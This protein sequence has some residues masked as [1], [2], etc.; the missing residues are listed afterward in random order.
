MVKVTLDV[1]A[2]ASIKKKPSS[3]SSG[4]NGKVKKTRDSSIAA[5][6]PA[7]K[8]RKAKP[9]VAVDPNAE[10][11][12]RRHRFKPGTVANREIRKYQHGTKA[13]EFLI[14]EAPI[15]RWIKEIMMEHGDLRLEKGAIEVIRVALEDEGIKVMS[16]ANRMAQHAN[17]KTIMPADMQAAKD[18]RKLHPGRVDTCSSRPD[19]V[20]FPRLPN[21]YKAKSSTLPMLEEARTSSPGRVTEVVSTCDEATHS[22]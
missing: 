2:L 15:Y 22:T 10:K 4:A 7:K 1:N 17:R 3:S 12:K 6:S 11:P 21:Q 14:P 5:S 9:K 13:T 18:V 19:I 20:L 8:E 16:T